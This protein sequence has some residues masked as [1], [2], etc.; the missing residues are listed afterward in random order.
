MKTCNVSSS[1]SMMNFLERNIYRNLS[2]HL[3][4]QMNSTYLFSKIY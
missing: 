4:S 2:T 3:G 1:N